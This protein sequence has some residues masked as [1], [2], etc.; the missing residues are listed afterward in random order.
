MAQ[1]SRRYSVVMSKW[2]FTWCW[3]A[4]IT[5]V[6]LHNSKLPE[7]I[8][9]EGHIAFIPGWFALKHIYMSDCTFAM[10]DCISQMLE[11][12]FGTFF[13]FFF[14]SSWLRSSAS[15]GCDRYHPQPLF[16]LYKR[17]V[18]LQPILT[19]W[20]IVCLG[21]HSRKGEMSIGWGTKC[22]RRVLGKGESSAC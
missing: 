3:N 17:R 8:Y 5:L 14:I 21:C 11:T 9:T 20:T 7:C 12:H 13:T 15:A 10:S 22:S 19:K 4:F 2:H 16:Q 1:Y 18:W 6:T